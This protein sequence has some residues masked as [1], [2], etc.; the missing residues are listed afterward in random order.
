[1]IDP[2]LLEALKKGDRKAFDSLIRLYYPRLMA[3]TQIIVDGEAARDIVQDV[4]LYVWENRARINFTPA[5]HSY[6]FKMCYSRSVDHLRRK[7]L[8]S[9]MDISSNPLLGDETAWL[10]NNTGDIVK[11]LSDTDLLK[12]VEQ[13]IDQLP[14]KRREVF[15]LSFFYEMSNPEIAQLLDMPQRTVESHLYLSLKFL[16]G[17]ISDTDVL[18]LLLML[19]NLL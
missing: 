9:D 8:L 18:L 1:M 7:K 12:R 10:K 11:I 16:R 19:A 4:F 5:F 15:R 17:K 3:Y 13:L 14:E 2:A 6:L